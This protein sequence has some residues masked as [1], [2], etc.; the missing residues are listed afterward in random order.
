MK[1]WRAKIAFTLSEVLIT[2]G[3]IGV[4]A[5]MT[6]PLLITKYQD[7][8]RIVKLK[9][10]YS[11]MMQAHKLVV[12][13]LGEYWREPLF[14]AHTASGWNK[15]EHP[16]IAKLYAEKIG[17]ARYCGKMSW[18]GYTSSE[19]CKSQ[20]QNILGLNGEI[21]GA[22]GL[23]DRYLLILPD[24]AHITLHFSAGHWNLL[25]NNKIQVTVGLDINGYDAPNQV[26][27]DIFYFLLK[28]NNSNLLPN[29]Y[30]GAK[31]ADFNPDFGTDVSTNY[32][33]ATQTDCTKRGYGFSCSYVIMNNGW[34][35]PPNYHKK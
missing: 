32:N 11:V 16:T 14:N 20:T 27:K 26:G 12:D 5:A 9:K 35:F 18:P 6:I 13:D 24:G 29:N 8:V 34:H 17:N 21:V 15:A 10:L 2:L 28:S 23:I 4:V 1:C 19:N 31:G 22:S 25:Q 3:V 30:T 7:T 33:I